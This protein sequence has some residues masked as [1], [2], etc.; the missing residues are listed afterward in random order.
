[1]ALKTLEELCFDN[2]K[3][4]KHIREGLGDLTCLKKLWMNDYDSLEEFPLGVT[5]LKALEELDFKGCKALKS[6]SEGL[7]GLTCLKKLS[8]HECKTLNEFPSRVT[9]M[10]KA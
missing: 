10:L 1:M 5:T 9:F 7:G 6:I 2:C 4:L 3:T 8:M